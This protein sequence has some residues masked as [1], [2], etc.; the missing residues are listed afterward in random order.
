MFAVNRK[1]GDLVL[2]NRL[3]DQVT[4]HDKGLLVGQSDIL[5]RLDCRNCGYET[6]GADN[7]GHDG[8]SLGKGGDTDIAFP[9]HKDPVAPACGKALEKVTCHALVGD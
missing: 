9:A 3:H 4:G 8:V 6:G 2:F 7:C 5:A 1:Q